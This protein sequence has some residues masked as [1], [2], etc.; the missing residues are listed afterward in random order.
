[1]KLYGFQG[2]VI[3]AIAG[4]AG[5]LSALA[6]AAQQANLLSIVPPKYAW[7][8]PT[9]SIV[10]LF[11]TLFSERVTGGASLPSVR[12]A[13]ESSDRKNEREAMNQ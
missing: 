8:L 10:G 9:V 5:V 7:T 3:S 11:L 6:T 2:R 13:A 1:M 12:A 4:T